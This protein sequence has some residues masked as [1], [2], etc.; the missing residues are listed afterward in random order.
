VDALE[1]LLRAAPCL[2]GCEADVRCTELALARRLL[3]NKAPFAPLRLHTFE[4]DGV[5]AVPGEAAVLALA[6]DTA[7]HAHLR[8]LFLSHSP[9]NTAAALDA[10]VDAALTR[11]LT[12]VTL[13][14]CDLS[15]ESAPALVRLIGGGA[16]AQLHIFGEADLLLDAASALALGNALRL[17]GT[18]TALSLV[19]GEI[20]RHPAAGNALLGALTG[21]PRLRSLNL[22]FNAVVD[23]AGQDEVG[24]ALGALVAANAPALQEMHLYNCWLGDAGLRPLFDALPAN[25]HLRTLDCSG[26]MLFD[27]FVR[28]ALLPAVRANSSVRELMTGLQSDARGGG[29]RAAPRQR[30]VKVAA[31]KM[32]SAGLRATLPPSAARLGALREAPAEQR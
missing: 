19:S 5:D 25:T 3:R 24:A 20:W 8:R 32:C 21:H 26:N 17:S 9:L 4:F 12:S 15:L 23:A 14:W 16:L 1:N 18:L 22:S 31:T 6:A 7:S 2:D 28:D 13:R 29:A 10:V 30:A 11:Q 27:A